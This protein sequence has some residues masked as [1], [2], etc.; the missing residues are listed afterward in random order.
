[1][2]LKRNKIKILQM[3]LRIKFFELEIKFFYLKYLLWLLNIPFKEQNINLKLP[4]N[5]IVKNT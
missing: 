2:L 5:I 1:M 4:F 3:A